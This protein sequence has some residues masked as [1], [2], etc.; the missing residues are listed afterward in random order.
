MLVFGCVNETG[1]VDAADPLLLPGDTGLPRTCDDHR[2]EVVTLDFP[3]RGGCRFGQDGNLDRRNEH[4][5]AYADQSR[6]V[7]L[8]EGSQICTLTLASGGER[9][10]FDDHLAIVVGDVV[11]VSGGSGGALDEHPVRD[12]LPRFDWAAIRGRPFADRYTDY[13]CLG[14]GRCQ[15]PRT[16]ERGPLDVRIDPDT[17]ADIARSLGVVDGLDIGIVTFGDDDQGDCAHTG[18]ALDVTVQ[19]V[20]GGLQ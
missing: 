16:E 2:T 18:L 9:A 20:P 8:P 7:A 14:G 3:A 11:I 17:M 5:Q 19:Y 15:V 4:L 1:L 13:E 10:S 6:F 12:G